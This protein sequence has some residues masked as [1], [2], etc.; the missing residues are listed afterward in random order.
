[1]AWI[2]PVTSW[3]AGN[4]IGFSD[5][6]RIEGDITHIDSIFMSSSGL[7]TIKNSGN[8]ISTFSNTA[9]E[10]KKDT[11][12]VNAG[13]NNAIVFSA[14]TTWTS[15]SQS[16]II[17]IFNGAGSESIRID[18]RNSKTWFNTNANFII[19]TETDSGLGKF[20]VTGAGVFSGNLLVASTDTDWG[21]SWDTIQLSDKITIAEGF[22]ERNDTFNLYRDNSAV[23]RNRST[24]FASSIVQG[25]GSGGIRLIAYNS[26]SPGALST[27]AGSIELDASGNT[28]V[29]GNIN[30]TTTPTESTTGN[31][32]SGGTYMIPRGIYSVEGT[33]ITVG[34]GFL[35]LEKLINGSW[36]TVGQLSATA[37]SLLSDL[38][39][40]TGTDLRLA[41]SGTLTASSA[42]L[43]KY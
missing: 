34:G 6:N 38:S 21:S 42:V 41:A 33:L 8:I 5:L 40:S 16:A 3:V 28:N 18:G 9:I 4:G 14:S 25:G 12:L 31:I 2:T 15:A 24:G 22:G 30:P 29:S 26:L 19:G 23:H 37:S 1:M 17:Q 43:R 11:K 35:R 13:G 27:I 39:P 10:L 32:A 7:A 20:Q 36:H